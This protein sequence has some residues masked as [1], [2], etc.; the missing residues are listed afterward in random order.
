MSSMMIEKRRVLKFAPF[1]VLGVLVCFQSAF[2][3]YG[4]TTNLIENL[5]LSIFFVISIL[6]IVLVG[7]LIVEYFKFEKRVYKKEILYFIAVLISLI[8]HVVFDIYTRVY[9]GGLIN[10]INLFWDFV[11]GS[12]FL[13]V[14]YLLWK[15]L[16][17]FWAYFS[18]LSIIICVSADVALVIYHQTL[19]LEIFHFL[20]MFAVFIGV[21]FLI[22]K[23]LI[24]TSELLKDD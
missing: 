4:L 14:T 17:K 22:I 8:I 15:K 3:F 5:G 2:I 11:L 9:N 23:Y 16:N 10:T 6:F 21:Y 24:D 19:I 1:F 20:S 18:S 13:I 7:I 12:L